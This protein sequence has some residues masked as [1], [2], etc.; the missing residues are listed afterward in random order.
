MMYV[1]AI[2]FAASLVASLSSAD[3]G[4]RTERHSLLYKEG[5]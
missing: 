3:A 4:R 2:A 5:N 1:L